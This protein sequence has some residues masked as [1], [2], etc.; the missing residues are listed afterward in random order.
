[1]NE[2][3]PEEAAAKLAAEPGSTLLL[4]VREVPEVQAA[5]VTGAI[6]IPMG[7]IPAR[8]AELDQSKTVICMCHLGGRSAQVAAFLLSQGYTAI[9]MAGGIEGWSQTVDPEVPRY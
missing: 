4:D 5:S 1:M 3:T 2:L 8:L 7:E 6:H 9:N